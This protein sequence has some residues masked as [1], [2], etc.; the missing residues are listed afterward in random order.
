M[1]WPGELGKSRALPD[2]AQPHIKRALPAMARDAPRQS[3]RRSGGI[4]ATRATSALAAAA[5]RARLNRRGLLPPPLPVT[6]KAILA[7][8]ACAWRRKRSSAVWAWRCVMP[9]R[10]I[11]TSIALRPRATRCLS[12]RSNGASGGDLTCGAGFCGTG[13]CGA[14]GRRARGAASLGS[15]IG[16]GIALAGRNGVIERAMPAHNVCSSSLR[17]RRRLIVLSTASWPSASLRDQAGGW[18][19]VCPPPA[20]LRPQ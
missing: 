9:C 19:L 5:R 8:S 17:C 14:A 20:A 10:S 12:R 18:P 15:T 11:R 7:S 16:F 1:A 13:F 6:T 3:R 2:A 4:P